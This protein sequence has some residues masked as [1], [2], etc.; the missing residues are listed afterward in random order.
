MNVHA[1]QP[2]AERARSPSAGDRDL[3]RVLGLLEANRTR[4]LTIAALRERGIETP[5]IR[6]YELQVAGYEIERVPCERPD[7]HTTLGYRLR[8]APVPTI[9]QSAQ[10]KEVDSDEIPR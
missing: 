6:V 1:I 4:G 8:A 2:R 3:T 10:L 7:G 9:D 5:A